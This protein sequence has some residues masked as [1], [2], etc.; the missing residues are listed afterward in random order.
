VISHGTGG[1]AA[2]HYDTAIALADAG[3]VVVALTHAGDNYKDRSYSFTQR[4]FVERPR[5][6]SRVVD[7]M[8]KDWNGHDHLDPS[9]IGMF[10]HS[11]GGATA[12][13]SLGGNPDFS[14]VALYCNKHPD[15]WDCEQ[16]KALPTADPDESKPPEWHHDPR[17]KVA[18]IAAPAI[19]YTFTKDG[20]AAVT[21]PIQLWRAENDKIAVNQW[22]ADIISA[23]LP[24]LPEDHLV[25]NA[26]HFDFLAPCTDALAKVAPEICASAPGF[27]R[28]AFH[29][30][31]N[32]ALITFFKAQLAAPSP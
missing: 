20:L 13:I 6:V 11:A 5:Q 24:K 26:A 27:D 3:F 23:A 32:K 4:N 22:N 10:G 2:S 31:F 25:A 19:G 17:V 18:A 21:A 9:R 16:I 28:T 7:F 1:G 15:A 12:L 29:A 14:R 8:L 30:D